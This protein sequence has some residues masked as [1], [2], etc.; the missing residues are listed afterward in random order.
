M[1]RV[2]REASIHGEG[3]VGLGAR[4]RG[5]FYDERSG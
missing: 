2:V 1:C 4:A 3:V 5:V